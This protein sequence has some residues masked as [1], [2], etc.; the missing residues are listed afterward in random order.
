[1]CKTSHIIPSALTLGFI[2][3]NFVR[4]NFLAPL[5]S[6]HSVKPSPS[7]C[8]SARELETHPGLREGSSQSRGHGPSRQPYAGVHRPSQLLRDKNKSVNKSVR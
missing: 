3:V 7:P 8:S 6:L 5:S 2:S 4:A 1:M